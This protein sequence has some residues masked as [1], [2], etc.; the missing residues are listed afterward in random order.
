MRYHAIAILITVVLVAGCETWGTH[1]ELR[2][3]GSGGEYS[4]K[5]NPPELNF[6]QDVRIPPDFTI[7]P[8]EVNRLY[9]RY[10]NGHYFCDFFVDDRY[11]YLVMNWNLGFKMP[12]DSIPSSASV[13]VDGRS[14]KLLKPEEKDA[15]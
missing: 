9:R 15:L 7:S 6:E 4:P 14:G 12:W 1:G 8:E 5:L 2:F 11:Y 13:I 3:I 10:C